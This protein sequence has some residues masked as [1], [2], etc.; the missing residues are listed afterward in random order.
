MSTTITPPPAVSRGAALRRATAY[1]YRHLAGLRSTWVVLAVALVL[2]IG[3]GVDLGFTDAPTPAL[4]ADA[5]QWQPVAM[6]LPLLALLLIA[7]GTGPAGSDL[8]RGAARTTWL[9]AASRGTAFAAKLAIG[10]AVCAA[11][12]AALAL[13]AAAAAATTLALRGTAQ[14]DWAACVPAVLRYLLVMACWPVLAA[15]TAAIVRNRAATVLLLVGWPLLGERLVGA[16]LGRLLDAD[17]LGGWLPFAA[18]RAAMA[19]TSDDAP[20]DGFTQALLGSELSPAAGLSVFLAFT[21][22]TALAGA[23]AY[24]RRDA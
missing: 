10:A 21:A 23:F 8:A 22:A 11:T 4:A 6:Q 20:Q 12:A 14:P 3:N 16:L 19:G 24:Q 15:S 1:E 5:L 18:A 9:V 17:G 13:L 2:G 7:F